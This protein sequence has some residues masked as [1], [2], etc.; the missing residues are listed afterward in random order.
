M[1]SLPHVVERIRAHQS[2]RREDMGLE[3]RFVSPQI[4]GARTIGVLSTPTGAAR[5]L[6]WVVCHSLALEQI[7]LQ[8]YEVAIARRLSAD[9]YPVLRFQGQG[10]GDS[11]KPTEAITLESHVG[12]ALD[13]IDVLVAET[14]VA[15]VGLLGAR[16]GGSTALEAAT[17][18]GAGAVVLWDP[19]V[20]GSRYLRS[21]SRLEA[22]ADVTDGKQ[23][24]AA[25]ASAETAEEEANIEGFAIADDVLAG[26]RRFDIRE[27]IEGFSAHC[28]IVQIA[29]SS[30][31]SRG[32]G[33]LTDHL[34]A[35]GGVVDHELLDTARPNRFGAPRF[36]AL[37][38][39]TK[40]DSQA[41][42]SDKL[43]RLTAG[44]IARSAGSR[45]SEGVAR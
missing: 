43:I 30:A 32:I 20:F 25:E 28:L 14:G 35:V 18:A 42:L 29:R 34:R 33:A 11:D 37:A 39:G 5:S 9:G 21:L 12:D 36:R 19:V 7:Y 45:R 2:F 10:Y 22:V 4:G 13:A 1:S 24:S 6:G 16:F 3:E 23:Q 41:E 26:L 8:P 27:R 15:E 31:H 38:D 17:R 40:T 44:W